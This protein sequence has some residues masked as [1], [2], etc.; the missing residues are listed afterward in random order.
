MG[1]YWQWSVPDNEKKIKA[2]LKD[3]KNPRFLFYAARLFYRVR[4]PKKAFHYVD[5]VTFCKEWPAIKRL[6]RKNSWHSDAP[7]FWQ[8]IY[9]STKTELKKDG[10]KIPAAKKPASPE[11]LAV[12]EQIKVLRKEKGYTQRELADKMKVIQQYISTLESGR[13][14][15]SVSTLASVAKALDK[16]LS[17]KFT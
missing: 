12:A 6:I 1:R 8:T 11:R 10:V 17:I 4:D 16:K 13:E 14:N 2:V 3:N 7:K 5:K 15:F 9:D